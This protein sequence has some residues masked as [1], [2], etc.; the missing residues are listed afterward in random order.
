MAFDACNSEQCDLTRESISVLQQS[1]L[2]ICKTQD[3]GRTFSQPKTTME[4][5]GLVYPR[6]VLG[7]TLDGRF[8]DYLYLLPFDGYIYIYSLRT[9]IFGLDVKDWPKSFTFIMPLHVTSYQSI[10]I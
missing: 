10:L 3:E 1:F 5:N 9:C 7:E 2:W 6:V 8:S 4:F